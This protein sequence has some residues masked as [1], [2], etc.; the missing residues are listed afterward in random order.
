M[1]LLSALLSCTFSHHPEQAASVPTTTTAATWAE[2]LTEPGVITHEAVVSARW[3][4]KR[5]GLIDLSDPRAKE[6]GLKDGK[7]P[8]VLPVHALSHPGGTVWV[9]DSGIDADLAAGGT[10][11]GKGPLKGVLKTLEP[12]EPLGSIISRQAGD[13]AG[14][15]I[16]HM[17]IDH[18]LGLPDVPTDAAIYVGPGEQTVRDGLNALLRGTY[19]N[20]LDSRPP[21]RVWGCDGATEIEGFPA[22]DVIGDG[23]LWALCT[24]G[25]T[26]GSMTFLARTTDGPALFLGDTSHTRWGWDNRVPPGDYTV[27]LA[28]N[29][30]SLNKLKGLVEKNPQITVYVGHEL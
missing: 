24:P 10:G 21:L 11:A 29:R 2:I 4:G 13:L 20:L 9:V 30:V 6:A 28:Q 8:I 5:S 16:T 26:P 22:I 27:D 15:L 14:V 19:R 7:V 25:H 18:V 17:H 12:V 23:S 1:L 3:E